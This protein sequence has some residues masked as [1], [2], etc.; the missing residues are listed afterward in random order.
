MS[1]F[2][3]LIRASS[4]LR[5]SLLLLLLLSFKVHA[6]QR[7][8]V[9]FRSRG[10]F[11]LG[12]T[13]INDGD[14]R[15]YPYIADL[16]LGA[17]VLHNEWYFKV[18]VGVSGSKISI[19]DLLFNYDFK[20]SSLMIGN[21][22]EPF[23]VDMTTSSVDLSFNESASSAQALAINGRRF[24]LTYY[25]RPKNYFGAIGIYTDNSIN[26]LF[27]PKTSSSAI[28]ITTRHVYRRHKGDNLFQVGGAVSLRS[29]DNS[30]KYAEAGIVKLSSYGNSSLYSES[31][32]SAKIENSNAVLKNNV[33]IISTI[34]RW[35]IQAELTGMY[36]FRKSDFINYKAYGGY[37]QVSYLFGKSAYGYDSELALPAGPKKGV[38]IAAR[39]DYVNTNDEKCKIYG[40]EHTD[41]SLGVNY[42]INKW[43]AAKLNVNYTVAGTNLSSNRFL[44]LLRLQYSF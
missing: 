14:F 27:E 5:R 9:K 21:G 38:E 8:D 16:R 1:Y 31:I 10:L 2:V 29:V 19:K 11:D 12:Y 28:A 43:F 17:K 44:S 7:V 20:N 24:G 42:Y 35:K 6:E 15:L 33:E 25:M 36:V 34:N 39:L 13:K 40:G 37:L 3:M 32:V 4:L 22:Y 26:A 23:N 41:F 30:E 18:D